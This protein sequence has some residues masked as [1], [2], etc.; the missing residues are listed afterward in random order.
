MSSSSALLWKDWRQLRPLRWTG[1]ALGLLLPLGLA[2]VT[3]A[4]R[5]GMPLLGWTR[6]PSGPELFLDIIPVLLGLGLWPLWALVASIQAFGADRQAGTERFLLERPVRR[7]QVWRSRVAVATGEVLVQVLSSILAW[8]VLALAL[9]GLGP[10][11]LA[12][13]VLRSLG[14]AALTIPACFGAGALA[15]SFGLPS[16]AA[17]VAGGGLAALALLAGLIIDEWYYDGFLFTR[18][19]TASQIVSVAALAISLTVSYL[20]FSR[21]E[22]MGRRRL[23]RGLA[24]LGTGLVLFTASFLVFTIALDRAHARWLLD[25]SWM[26]DD[27]SYLK[28]RAAPARTAFLAVNGE[29]GWLIDLEARKRKVFL[30][31]PLLPYSYAWSADGR[32]LAVE[33]ESS[34]LGRW[35]LRRRVE[36]LD[37]H[38]R[39]ACPPL[40]PGEGEWIRSF[41]WYGDRLLVLLDSP[42]SRWWRIAALVPGSDE[43]PRTIAELESAAVYLV[44]PA[45][46]GRA[47]LALPDGDAG[48]GGSNSGESSE[49]PLPHETPPLGLFPLDPVTGEIGSSA[50]VRDW[51]SFWSDFI[52][53]EKRLS[54]SGRYWRLRG[55][56]DQ[57]QIE[58][59]DLETGERRGLPVHGES[60]YPEW[61]VGD[62]LVWTEE[63]EDRWHLVLGGPAGERRLLAESAADIEMRTAV[64]PDKRKIWVGEMQVVEG[65]SRLRGGYRVYD[66]ESESWTEYAAP[67]GLEAGVRVEWAGP[68]TLA[69][70]SRSEIH[71]QRLE[72]PEEIRKVIGLW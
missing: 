67:A 14:W 55:S 26:L 53:R 39:P 61:L 49:K 18:G 45:E 35:W 60:V 13:A 28:V 9:A 34:P 62:R 25:W 8:Q 1:I 42:E 52:F 7:S 16:L 29:S 30:P 54:P 11:S 71:L 23:R 24:W 33:T 3:G 50:L 2:L 66:I 32:H 27:R 15:A 40:R 70:T 68:G 64:S 56:W 59:V 57:E 36:I 46:D 4:T 21:G 5:V 58:L 6:S 41:A 48:L 20:M 63:R 69:L 47:Y 31:P 65:R 44:S 43:E 10:G 38:G 22:P 12:E 19:S 37:R 17:L 72:A 51:W